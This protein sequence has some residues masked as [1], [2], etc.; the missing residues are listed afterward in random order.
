MHVRTWILVCYLSGCVDPPNETGVEPTLSAIVV[1]DGA[2]H[3]RMAPALRQQD[4][5]ASAIAHGCDCP[6][7]ASVP[8]T[9]MEESA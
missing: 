6:R 9:T 7:A 5:L 2:P 4:R 1:L 3:A 8:S